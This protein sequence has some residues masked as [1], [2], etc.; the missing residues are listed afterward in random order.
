MRLNRAKYI[1]DELRSNDPENCPQKLR[2]WIKKE[3][4]YDIY[5]FS[6]L[7]KNASELKKIK[8]DLRDFIAIYFQSQ[9]SLDVERWNIYQIYFCEQP[10]PLHEKVNL[11]ED[12]FATRK[13]MIDQNVA[14]NI[15]D[16]EMCTLIYDAI[17]KFK[18]EST[19]KE[20]PLLSD[21]IS[22]S[23]L[24]IV[25]LAVSAN[26]ENEEHLSNLV[27]RICDE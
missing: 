24:K 22:E 21:C 6:I 27:T 13:I 14:H 11:E 18:F 15:S 23:E 2:C 10:I 17:F 9:L 16:E 3:E 4:K 12:K 25:E 7:I 26:L 20:L 1:I 5:I 8:D 19:I